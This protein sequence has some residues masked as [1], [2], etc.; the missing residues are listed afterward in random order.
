MFCTCKSDVLDGAQF[1]LTHST[2][3]INPP[4]MPLPRKT[5]P[6]GAHA[7]G[8]HN[9]ISAAAAG[10]V[11]VASCVWSQYFPQDHHIGL[12]RPGDTR[13]ASYYS[14]VSDSEGRFKAAVAFRDCF[15]NHE[16]WAP[17]LMN[18]GAYLPVLVCGNGP[19]ANTHT[20]S[21]RACS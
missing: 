9:A 5:P 7:R 19:N 14:L 11:A 13:D 2:N 8:S 17:L 16:Q 1:P 4:S 18:V 20:H 3:F 6:R 15:R 21:R 10:V 12:A